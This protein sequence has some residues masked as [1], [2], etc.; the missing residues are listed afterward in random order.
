LCPGGSPNEFHLVRQSE[1]LPDQYLRQHIRS[2]RFRIELDRR[3]RRQPT[4]ALQQN[5]RNIAIGANPEPGDHS[6]FTVSEEIND[7]NQRGI[8]PTAQQCGNR[9]PGGIV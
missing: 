5:A 1:V 9:T 2:L 3:N 8:S 4:M 7:R 6:E